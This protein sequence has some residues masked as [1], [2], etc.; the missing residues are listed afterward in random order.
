MGKIQ[1]DHTGSGSGITLSSDG[2]SLLLD[3]T[4]VGG[5]GASDYTRDTKTANYTVVSGDLGKIIDVT[6]NSVTISLTAAATLGDGFYVFIRNSSSTA[7]HVVTID[8]NGSETID[9][10]PLIYLRRF[11]GIHLVCDGSGFFS[12]RTRVDGLQTNL[13]QNSHQLDQP[14]ASGSQAIAL[15]GQTDATANFATAV[16]YQAQATG[17]GAVGLGYSARATADYATSIG[18][19]T[20]A[21]GS[22]SVAL[23]GAGSYNTKAT[24]GN[25]VAIGS[26][27]KSEGSG[28]FTGP[29]SYASGNYSVSLGISN[30][31]TSYGATG[32]N[33]IAIGQLAKAT[34]ANSIAIG[35]T[36]TSTTANQIA[37][38]GTTDT[39]KI[40][41]T[42]TLPTSDGSANQV[43]TTNGSGVVTFAAASG[44]ISN[45]VE[46]TSPQLGG[47]LDVQAREIN[48]STTNGNIVF[49][50][51]GTGVV[52]V[53]GAGGND[54]TLQLNC[55]ANSH[56]VKIKSPP[57]SAGA[58]YTL[59]LPNDD[60][61]ASEFLQTN[62]SGVLTWAAAGA[63]LYAANPSSATDP[64]ASG[65]NAVAIGTVAVASGSL[66][67][68]VG[69]GS[70]ASAANAFAG[71]VSNS[72]GSSSVALGIGTNSTSYGATGNYS[73][74]VGY[75]SK[76]TGSNA[77]AIGDNAVSSS[78]GSVAIGEEATATG[79]NTFAVG[80]S[81]ASATGAT[82]LNI[83]NSSSSYGAS[84]PN[85]FAVGD[86]AKATGYNSTAIGDMPIAS[87]HYATSI[88]RQTNATAL[89]STA[90]G[91]ASKSSIYG[92]LAY[93]S[94]YFFSTYGDAQ[95]GQFILRGNT[96]DATAKVLTTD[97]E[98]VDSDNQVIANSDTCI[99][100]DGT[101]TAMQNGAQAYGSWKIEGL[102]VNDGGTTTLANSAITVIQNSSNWG[103]ALSAD[104]TNNAL[105]ITCTGEANH[106][107]R[108]VAN[109]RTSEV[110]YA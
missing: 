44:G 58:S 35:D 67:T 86:R 20:M 23:G 5:G 100:F 10:S 81:R 105:A 33:S 51:N 13:S 95:G 43:L 102:L 28:S 109:I 34:A 53:K 78:S 39:V 59:T 80:K 83:E 48:T 107:I 18:Y 85:S 40:S 66:S 99:S 11:E 104:N 37:L 72:S 17:D 27:S 22:G 25:A 106:N 108:W 42:Y 16:G 45:V 97:N 93:A 55:S 70:L 68:A 69:H 88:G 4:A 96:T 31:S 57:H 54:G 26:Y 56:G 110:T 101:I 3:G 21:T 47:N 63:D 50:P 36:A 65:T 29:Y 74:A 77:I 1:L 94:G 38:G 15:G 79:Y 32:A 9:G 60:G 62:G 6:S 46:D 98:A 12:L 73:F 24:G 14:T 84:N 103:L 2:T 19:F 61:D 64:V 89:Y 30:G 49:N 76:A 90:L 75:Q 92:K 7:T 91:F 52:E 87:N 82:A 71:P 41:G 8:G